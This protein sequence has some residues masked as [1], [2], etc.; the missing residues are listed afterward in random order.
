MSNIDTTQDYIEALQADYKSA[1]E[2]EDFNAAYKIGDQIEKQQGLLEKRKIVAALGD[3]SIS[4]GR[5]IFQSLGLEF[6]QQFKYFSTGFIVD[7]TIYS[8]CFR[9]D[10]SIQC[11]TWDIYTPRKRMCY[12]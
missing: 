2:W 11:W 7:D 8:Q 12:L 4:Q 6:T 10:G 9:D 1:V 3:S 5:G